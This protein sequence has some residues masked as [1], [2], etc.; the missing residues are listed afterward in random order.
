[1]NGSNQR[2]IS[3]GD[4]RYSTPVWSPRGDLIAFTRQAGGQ[5]AIGVMRPDGSG[6]RILTESYLDEAPTWSPNGRVIMFFQEA[7]PGAGP[8]LWSVDLTGRNLRM[9]ATQTDASDPAWSPLLP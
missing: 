3:F 5:F 7:R 4:G 6:E 9:A 2:R 8:K 1:M